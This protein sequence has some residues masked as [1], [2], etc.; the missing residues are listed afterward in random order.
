MAPSGN[1]SRWHC[2]TISNIIK[3]KELYKGNE[4]IYNNENNIYWPKIID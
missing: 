2:G 4:L 3:R 1:S